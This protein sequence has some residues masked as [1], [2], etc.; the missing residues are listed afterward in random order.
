MT[1]EPGLKRMGVNRLS[2]M[3]IDLA[4]ETSMLVIGSADTESEGS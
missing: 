1:P 3:D 4:S 2:F